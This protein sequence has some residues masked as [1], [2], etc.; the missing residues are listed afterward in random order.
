VFGDSR[1]DFD[2]HSD[3][4]PKLVILTRCVKKTSPEIDGGS[5]MTGVL[6][7]NLARLRGQKGFSQAKAAERAGISRQA[8]RSL[9]SG[10]AEPRPATLHALATALDARVEDLLRPVRELKKVRFRAHKKMATRAQVLSDVARWLDDYCALEEQLGEKSRWE[11]CGCEPGLTPEECALRAREAFHLKK[12]ELV[13]D[14]CGLLEDNGIKVYL[15]QVASEGFF[16]LSVGQEEGGPAVV[17]N[18]WDRIS[19][20]RWIF[21]AA[22][23]LG[24]LLLHLNAYDVAQEQEDEEQ[25]READRFA[26]EFLMPSEVFWE[27]WEEARGRPLVD[28]VF[29]LKQI[30]R[31][32]YKTVLYR[33]AEKTGDK[34][35]WGKFYSQYKQ[36][37]GTSLTKKEEPGAMCAADFGRSPA[38]AAKGAEEPERSKASVFMDDR[39]WGLVRKGVESGQISMSRGAE[40]L[41]LTTREMRWVAAGWVR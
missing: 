37:A 41:G 28:R 30:F 8:Y 6:G 14:I 21:S 11:R 16:G 27:E 3:H 20:E 22:H 4:H 13:R 34:Q 24:H 33:V 19:V 25:E 12:G 7:P 26:S 32:S 39:L 1:S 36:R 18:T 10:E 15:P 23:E 35:L 40:I 17:V 29:K 31:V 9:E 38:P 2:C 5:H